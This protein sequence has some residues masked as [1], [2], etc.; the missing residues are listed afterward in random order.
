[1]KSKNLLSSRLTFFSLLILAGF[2]GRL[3]YLQYLQD[4]EVNSEKRQI[5]AQIDALEKKN[6]D[7]SN[8]LDYFKSDSFKERIAREQLNMQKPGEQVYS[9]R[10][11]E[12]PQTAGENRDAPQLSNPVKWL[13]YL[14]G[15]GR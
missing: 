3:K 4:K 11:Q 1:M 7:I 9:F 5:L 15:Q 14:S 13:N 10:A 6:Q 12:A 2:L 8:S